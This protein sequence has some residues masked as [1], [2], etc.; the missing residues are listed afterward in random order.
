MSAGTLVF[1]TTMGLVILFIAGLTASTPATPSVTGL[2]AQPGD[3]LILEV[4]GFYDEGKVFFS[5]QEERFN[6]LPRGS[7]APQLQSSPVE[8]LL[9]NSSKS[10]AGAL[11]DVL[12]GRHA[13]ESFRTPV[14]PPAKAFGEW[15]EERTLPRTIATLPTVVNFDGRTVIG[16]NQTFNATQ[17]V[18][19]WKARG[20]NLTVGKA[21]RCEDDRLWDC[22]LL[23]LDERQNLV[24]Y[25]RL[26]S[27]GAAYPVTAVISIQTGGD[28]RWNFTAQPSADGKTFA[29]RLS[30]P[31]GVRFQ[32]KQSLRPPFDA[33]TYLVLSADADTMKVRYSDV[34]GS[35]PTLV[36]ESVYYDIVVLRILRG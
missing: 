26:V 25:R 10:Q 33:G 9:D 35:N 8:F 5:T 16:Q 20:V 27:E 15:K 3:T 30:P 28:M 7:I 14:I 13:N 34:T 2:P 23:T 11:Y 1:P 17:Y 6:D 4:S 31:V 24:S 32:F 29:L 18:A 12:L 36:G 19:F 22:K 21:W